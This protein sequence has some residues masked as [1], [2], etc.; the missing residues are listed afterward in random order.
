MQL[1]VMVK[2][3]ARMPAWKTV[4][5]AEKWLC[6]VL[7]A[8]HMLANIQR[9]FRSYLMAS[10]RVTWSSISADDSCDS[11]PSPP[12]PSV[13]SHSRMINHVCSF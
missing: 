7:D 12:L 10:K 4:F 2:Q 11:V 9:N 8:M 3:W 13:G 6:F 1:S 5:C